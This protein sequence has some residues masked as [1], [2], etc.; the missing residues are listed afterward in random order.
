M[1]NFSIKKNTYKSRSTAQRKTNKLASDSTQL[2]AAQQREAKKLLLKKFKLQQN[3]K[4]LSSEYQ[5]SSEKENSAE[6]V[7]P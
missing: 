7:R 2:S 3:L 6:Q 1:R 4:S 5:N